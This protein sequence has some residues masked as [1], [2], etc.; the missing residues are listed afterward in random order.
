M[1]AYQTNTGIQSSIDRLRSIGQA[2]KTL[3]FLSYFACRVVSNPKD[4]TAR[5]FLV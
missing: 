3:N 5:S 2:R 4:T 1:M